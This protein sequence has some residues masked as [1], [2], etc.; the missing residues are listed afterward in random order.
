[1]GKQTTN[2]ERDLKFQ[3]QGHASLKGEVP[4]APAR[5]H[6]AGA[7]GEAMEKSFSQMREH[8][9]SH[10]DQLREMVEN[11]LDAIVTDDAERLSART[12][13]IKHFPCRCK[14]RQVTGISLAILKGMLDETAVYTVEQ[15]EKFNAFA[16]TIGADDDALGEVVTAFLKKRQLQPK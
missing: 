12:E 3:L 4:M 5:R 9:L 1:M 7:N 14:G 13:D 11:G 16:R 6:L 15:F 10:K 8:V 2:M